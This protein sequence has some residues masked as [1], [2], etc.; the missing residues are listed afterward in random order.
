MIKKNTFFSDQFLINL[1]YNTVQQKRKTKEGTK[2]RIIIA[3]SF[4]IIELIIEFQ[5]RFLFHHVRI[6]E[7]FSF[8]TKIVL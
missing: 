6:L 2:K 5:F 8:V 3:R 7:I 4:S 1:K